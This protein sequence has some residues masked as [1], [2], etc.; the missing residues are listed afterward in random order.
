MG[1]HYFDDKTGSMLDGN[2]VKAAEKEE[3]YFMEK[4]GVGKDSAEEECW[5]LTGKPPIVCSSQHRLRR[6]ARN[7]C[8][9]GGPRFQGEGSRTSS[10]LFVSMPPLEA[11]KMLFR[12]AVR[13]GQSWRRGK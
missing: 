5:R 7:S 1:R 9:I 4:L 11:K 12:Q 3:L 13:E 8:A 6:Q 2:L 10:E